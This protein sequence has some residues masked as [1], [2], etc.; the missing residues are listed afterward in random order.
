MTDPQ[1]AAQL[2]GRRS[3]EQAMAKNK[4]AWLALYAEDALLQ[5]PVG[6]SPLDPAGEGHRGKAALARF[7]DM[8][9]AP[10]ELTMNI[11]ESYPS[12]NECANVVT[13]TNKLPAGGTIVTDCVI[14]YRVD[15]A[16]L[17]VNLK[18]YWEF[19]KVA[20]QLEKMAGHA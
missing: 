9:I 19:A 17:I 11:R 1:P 7:W 18:A 13:I 3:A 15:A 4:S 16:G 2:A 20:A 8:A 14:V 12:G 6:V 5:D 10:G